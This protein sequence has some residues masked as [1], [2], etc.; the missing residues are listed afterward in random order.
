M[1]FPTPTMLAQSDIARMS[2]IS[3]ARHN[4]RIANVACEIAADPIRLASALREASGD[5]LY[6]FCEELIACLQS[7]PGLATAVSSICTESARAQA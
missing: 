6:A 7:R 5:H 1:N 4:A 3:D 2:A